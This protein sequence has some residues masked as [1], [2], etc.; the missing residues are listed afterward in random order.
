MPRKPLAA[1]MAAVTVVATCFAASRAQSSKE[2]S[3]CAGEGGASS[4][5][6]ISNC[7]TLIESG[8]ETPQNLALAFYNR[9]GGYARKG[10]ADRALQDYNEAIR[11]DPTDASAFTN[12]GNVYDS[13]GQLDRALQDYA[14]A[15]RLDPSHVS[16]FFNRALAYAR[17]RQLD[18]AIP[19]YDQAIRLNPQHATALYG[20]GLAKQQ[21]GDAAAGDADIAAAKAIRSDIAELFKR[22]RIP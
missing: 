1:T 20:R 21:K 3:L 2:W 6:Q 19:D 12:R 11:L 13:K 18:R 14:Q 22:Y 15:I 10:D 5:V 8:R 17:R 9:A 7:T 4:D 16:A